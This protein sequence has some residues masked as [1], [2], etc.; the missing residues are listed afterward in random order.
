M[1]SKTIFAVSLLL[2]S[3]AVKSQ[4]LSFIQKQLDSIYVK[5][6]LVGGILIGVLDNDKRSFFT[7]GYAVPEIGRAHV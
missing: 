7:T 1:S 4:D 3:N 6:K 2:I 5:E